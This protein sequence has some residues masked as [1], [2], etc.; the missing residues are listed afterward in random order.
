MI[1]DLKLVN[2]KPVFYSLG[3][4]V[5]DQMWSE[6]TKKGMVG[7]LTYSGAKLRTTDKLYVYM[8]EFAQPKW[9]SE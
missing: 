2:D 7:L 6:E 3:N 8:E 9:V 4:F 5:F 1:Q